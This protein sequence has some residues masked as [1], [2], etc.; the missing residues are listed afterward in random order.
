MYDMFNVKGHKVTRRI[1]RQKRYNSA[2]YG[3]INF[4]P[5]GNLLTLEIRLYYGKLPQWT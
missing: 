5:G 3:H 2:V 1:S 4:K